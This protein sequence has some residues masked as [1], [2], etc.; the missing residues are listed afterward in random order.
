MIV[1][2]A[3]W[4]GICTE[5]DEPFEAGTEI[6]LLDEQSSKW[7]HVTCPELVEHQR[8]GYLAPKTSVEDMGY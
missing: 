3:H 7:R 4:P 8:P 6:C 2:E 1:I 5:C